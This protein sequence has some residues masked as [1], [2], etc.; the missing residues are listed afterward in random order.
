MTAAL[1]GLDLGTS[2][3]RAV[4]VDDSG[5]LLASASAGYDLS[6]PRPGWTEQDPALWW[7]AARR[8]LAEVAAACHG[9]VAGLGL[10]GQMHGSVFLDEA[11]DVIRPALL[12]NDQRTDAQCAEITRLVGASRL[13]EIA[14]QSSFFKRSLTSGGNDGGRPPWF[15]RPSYNPKPPAWAIFAG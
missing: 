5:S 11:G 6:M 10:T 8:V 13:L 2:G 15:I 12:W 3:A 4:A 1:L 9:E 7:Q 14:G